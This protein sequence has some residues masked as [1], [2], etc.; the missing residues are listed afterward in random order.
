MECETRTSR[1]KMWWL[2]AGLLMLWLP[3]PASAQK[4][5]DDGATLPSWFYSRAQLNARRA[6]INDLPECRDSV[7]KQIVVERMVSLIAPWVLTALVFWGAVVL[8]R[9]R[10]AK[11]DERS[12]RLQRNRVREAKKPRQA[13]RRNGDEDTQE[14]NEKDEA[15]DDGLGLGHPGDRRR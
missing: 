3:A 10:D 4:M 2:V 8:V 14:D 7:R 12:R 5:S 9:R 15:I 13:E 6:C 11:R 1:R